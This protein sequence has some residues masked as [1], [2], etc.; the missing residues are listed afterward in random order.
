MATIGGD[1][2]GEVVR[3]LLRRLVE[4][5]LATRITY[6]GKGNNNSSFEQFP[7]LISCIIGNFKCI[8]FSTGFLDLY[9]SLKVI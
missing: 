9:E 4:H 1:N 5:E 8:Q 6:T 2:V 3:N 7:H